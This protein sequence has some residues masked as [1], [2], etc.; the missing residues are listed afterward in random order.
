MCACMSVRSHLRHSSVACRLPDEDFTSMIF[1]T[2]PAI[3]LGNNPQH[4]GDHYSAFMTLS[5]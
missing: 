2:V 5:D 4:S 1:S 3:G